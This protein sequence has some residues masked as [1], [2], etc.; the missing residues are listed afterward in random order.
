MSASIH[1]LTSFIYLKSG[2]IVKSA[3]VPDQPHEASTRRWFLGSTSV[4]GLSLVHG[5]SHSQSSAAEEVVSDAL[6]YSDPQDKFQLAIPQ[7]WVYGTGDLGPPSEPGSMAARFGNSAGMKRVLAWFP[8]DNPNVSVSVTITPSGAD[9]TGLGSIGNADQWA[10]RIV[11]AMDTSYLLRAPDFVRKQAIARGQIPT[12]VTLVNA[13]ESQNKYMAEYVTSAD[14]NTTRRILTAV[15]LGS[16]GRLNRFYTV[17]A[18]AP[19]EIFEKYGEELR[20]AVDSF[21]APGM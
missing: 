9:Y 13:K 11:S 19:D 17:N 4:A 1:L 14:G 6:S 2:L 8:E 15:A 18:S 16:N 7:K 5:F 21:V 10:E 3:T 20:R 12:V